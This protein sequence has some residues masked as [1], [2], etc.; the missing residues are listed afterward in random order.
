M[1]KDGRL[2]QAERQRAI[3]WVQKKAPNLRCPSCGNPDFALSEHLTA[4]S[5]FQ[6][7]AGV[8]LGGP[9]YPMFF[10]VCTNCAHV[11]HYSAVTSGVLPPA[12]PG[13]T[14]GTNE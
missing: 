1:E 4:A 2:D 8:M 14:G 11:M 10:I 12:V 3:D 13:K 7:D 9:S 6:S 5:L